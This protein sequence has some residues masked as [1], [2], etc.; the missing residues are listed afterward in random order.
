MVACDAVGQMNA[1]RTIILVDFYFSKYALSMHEAC[2]HERHSMTLSGK[3]T[4]QASVCIMS[5]YSF[6]YFSTIF[7]QG[8]PRARRASTHLRLGAEVSPI[9]A[10]SAVAVIPYLMKC[11]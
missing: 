5:P 8:R 10:L 4:I 1:I 9:E 3:L 6:H 11:L 7:L 2:V